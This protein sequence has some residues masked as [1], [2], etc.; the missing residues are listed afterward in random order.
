MNEIIC[1]D[2]KGKRLERLT[3]WDHDITLKLT[4][5]SADDVVEVHICNFFSTEALVMEPTATEDGITI[6]IP[7]ILLTNAATI[8]V[9]I[10]CSIGEKGAY[11]SH[12]LRIPVRPRKK[13]ASYVYTETEVLS[14]RSLDRRVAALE[15]TGGAKG[16]PGE[17]GHTPEKG[18]DYW[19]ESDKAEI[20]AD[21]LEE[22][23]VWDGGS[24]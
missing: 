1:Y 12:I 4:D 22:L 24:Y 21:V 6:L 3:Q 2:N 15:A 17:P 14:Y 8:T 23:P 19:T 11:T 7:N 5:I 9:Y 10:Y 20:V 13:P 16:D 18:V